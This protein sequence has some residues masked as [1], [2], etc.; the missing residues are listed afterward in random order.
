MATGFA[1]GTTATTALRA[2]IET[3]PTPGIFL[4]L[5]ASEANRTDQEKNRASYASTITAAHFYYFCE[6]C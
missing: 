2:R 1:N 3:R 5:Y 6:Y 4:D